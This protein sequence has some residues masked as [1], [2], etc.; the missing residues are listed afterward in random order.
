MARQ[1]TAASDEGAS[2]SLKPHLYG[3][4]DGKAVEVLI[5]SRSSGDGQVVVR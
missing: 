5:F 1:K 2:G 4:V 3:T